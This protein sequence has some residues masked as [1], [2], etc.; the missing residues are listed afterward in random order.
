MGYTHYWEKVKDFPD[1]RFALF[2]QDVKRIIETTDVP[3]RMEFDTD[4]PPLVTEEAIHLNGVEEDGHET[5]GIVRDIPGFDF[6]KT[7][8]KPYDVVVCA[9]LIALKNR[10]KGAIR[11][12]SDGDDELG[13]PDCGWDQGLELWRKACGGSGTAEIRFGKHGLIIS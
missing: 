6:C 1:E 3:L 2:T 7:N 12:A 11:V 9:C 13:S 4:H 10:L 5:F 8:R